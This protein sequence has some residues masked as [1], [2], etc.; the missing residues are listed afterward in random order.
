MACIESTESANSAQEVLTVAELHR[1]MG[2]I[3]PSAAK[4]LVENG[5]VTGIQLD[6][7]GPEPTWCELCAYA[8]TKRKPVPKVGQGE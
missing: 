2:H 1:R 8:K 4:R 3:A 7:S 6:T 5:F